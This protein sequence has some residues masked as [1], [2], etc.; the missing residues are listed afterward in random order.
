[1]GACVDGRANDKGLK[2]GRKSWP[3]LRRYGPDAAVLI[4]TAVF[5]ALVSV[6]GLLLMHS[7]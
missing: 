6:I 5:L 1:M 2:S 3:L 4:A 7:H